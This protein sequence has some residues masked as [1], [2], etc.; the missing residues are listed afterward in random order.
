MWG[1]GG[2]WRRGGGGEEKVGHVL[3]HQCNLCALIFCECHELCSAKA[4]YGLYCITQT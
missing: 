3:F 2:G 4:V 1:G